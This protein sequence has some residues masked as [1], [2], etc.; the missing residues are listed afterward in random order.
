VDN[1]TEF[2]SFKR[3]RGIHGAILVLVAST[4]AMS[5]PRPAPDP[6]DVFDL[7]A[8]PPDSSNIFSLY[9]TLPN[10]HSDI[11]L[12]AYPIMDNKADT[13]TQSQMLKILTLHILLLVR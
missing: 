3:A 5:R 10:K 8:D 9:H 13:L 2:L 4:P 7:E 6:L 12:H 11:P 1:T